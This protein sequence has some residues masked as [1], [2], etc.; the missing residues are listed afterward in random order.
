MSEWQPISTA[1][2]EKDKAVLVW[3]GAYIAV[4]HPFDKNSWMVDNSYG[5]NEDGEIYNVT[6]WMPLPEPPK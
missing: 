4:A 3:D 1:T 2:R 6:H 5:I